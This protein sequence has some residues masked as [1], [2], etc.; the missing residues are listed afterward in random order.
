MSKVFVVDSTKQPLNP[1]HPG[2]A[3]LLLKHGKAA[4]YRRCPFTIILKRAVEQPSLQPLR[5]T[6][7]LTHLKAPLQDAAMVNATRWA[8]YARWGSPSNVAAAA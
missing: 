4:V 8:L 7:I 1:V 3:R 5:L 2:W 6:R